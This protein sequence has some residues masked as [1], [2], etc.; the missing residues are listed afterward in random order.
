[1]NNVRHVL[2]PGGLVLV[3]DY[4][5]YDL[6]QIRFGKHRMMEDNLYGEVEFLG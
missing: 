6:P 2:K 1:M 5:R 3:R 4:G